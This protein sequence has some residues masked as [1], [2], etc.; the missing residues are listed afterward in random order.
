[1][2]KRSSLLSLLKKAVALLF[3]AISFCVA[4]IVESRGGVGVSPGFVMWLIVSFR[5]LQPLR[6][7][8]VA[9]RF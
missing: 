6:I 4:P 8:N 5:V 3:L 7:R 9:Q 2:F 1:M